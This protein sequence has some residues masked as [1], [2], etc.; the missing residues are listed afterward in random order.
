LCT[1]WPVLLLYKEGLGPSKFRI[2]ICSI[3]TLPIWW[4]SVVRTCLLLF[5]VSSWEPWFPQVAAIHTYLEAFTLQVACSSTKNY[6]HISLLSYPSIP[7]ISVII[8]TPKHVLGSFLAIS[9]GALALV[10]VLFGSSSL[11]LDSIDSSSFP[12]DL[13]G[14]FQFLRSLNGSFA[15]LPLLIGSIGKKWVF[16]VSFGVWRKFCWVLET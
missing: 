7:S 5:L 4:L 6:N 13:F 12:I 8:W 15:F 9:F 10:H 3:K 14:A 16:H 11:L 2:G 1:L